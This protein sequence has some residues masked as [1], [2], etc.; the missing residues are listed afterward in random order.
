MLILVSLDKIRYCLTWKGTS[1]LAFKLCSFVRIHYRRERGEEKTSQ[2]ARSSKAPA[3]NFSG[4]KAIF[5]I[6][7]C[8]IVVQ[9][10]AH[11]PVNF[12]FLT[13]SLVIV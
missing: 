5:K 11:Q 12:A 13:D 2:G 4:S 9:F 7:T 8:R 1:A 3:E 6:K 10:L